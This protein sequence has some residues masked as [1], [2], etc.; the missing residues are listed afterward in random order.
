[1]HYGVTGKAGAGKDTAGAYLADKLNTNTAAIADPMKRLVHKLFNVS[2]WHA[3]DRV[4]KE[5]PMSWLLHYDNLMECAEL[6]NELGLDQYEP[7]PDA[8]D[9]WVKLLD[10]KLPE[11]EGPMSVTKSLR[12]LYQTIGTEWGR[13]INEDIWIKLFPIGAIATDVRMEN[14]ARYLLDKGYTLLEVTRPGISKVNEHSTEEGLPVDIPTTVVNNNGSTL[15]LYYKLD[16]L[17]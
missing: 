1:M 14:E 4:V 9:K 17:V 13:A 2:P 12:Q 6:Y 15:D 11:T 16:L 7:F 10:I 3:Q 5:K 8:F